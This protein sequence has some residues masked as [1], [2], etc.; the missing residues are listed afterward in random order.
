MPRYYF[1]FYEG[2]DLSPDQEGLE[3]DNLEAAE[4]EAI[5][6]A[7]QLGRDSPASSSRLQLDDMSGPTSSMKT[8]LIFLNCRTGSRRAST[9]IDDKMLRGP[10]GDMSS[11][12]SIPA[13]HEPRPERWRLRHNSRQ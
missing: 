4:H 8:F 5:Q 7:V 10:D 11:R 1:D 9:K 3:L 6:T 13:G 2:P 12:I